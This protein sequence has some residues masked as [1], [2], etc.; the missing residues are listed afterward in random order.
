MEGF[1]LLGLNLPFQIVISLL[2]AY[3][4]W[5]KFLNKGKL[6]VGSGDNKINN[7]FDIISI[8]CFILSSFTLF[9]L[10]FKI[11]QGLFIQNPQLHQIWEQTMDVIKYTIPFAILVFILYFRNVDFPNE[12]TGKL[13]LKRIARFIII[14]CLVITLSYFGSFYLLI[15]L[16]GLRYILWDLIFLPIIFALFFMFSYLVLNTVFNNEMELKI[17]NKIFIVIVILVTLLFSIIGYL[18]IPLFEYPENPNLYGIHIYDPHPIWGDAYLG[19]SVPINIT[20]FGYL[21]STIPLI[22]LRYGHYGINISNIPG[23]NFNIFVNRSERSSIEEFTKGI[24]DM[25]RYNERVTPKFGISRIH[26]NEEN[27]IITL[28][29]NYDLIK[30]QHINQIIFEGYMVLNRSEIFYSQVDNSQAPN[31]CSQSGC[32]LNIN[33]TNYANLP[34]LQHEKVLVNLNQKNIWNISACKFTNISVE[35]SPKEE[36][37]IQYIACSDLNCDFQLQNKQTKE[38]LCNMYVYIDEGVVKLLRVA[39]TAP[40]NVNVNYIISC[41]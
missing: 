26:L 3:L 24:E 27:Q 14:V 17:F 5:S 23:D 25:K 1:E 12:N 36:V 4:I 13:R 34:V 29:Y 39:S 15:I 2:F 38:V 8:A 40:L 31:I 11:L 18:S 19:V 30:P 6:T 10:F 37:I 22:P 7:I 32:T 16:T 33:V 9:M 21:Q 41:S 20:S 28:V 35:F